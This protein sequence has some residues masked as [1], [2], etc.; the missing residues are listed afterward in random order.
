MNK[1]LQ[2]ILLTFFL[3]AS[4]LLSI[5]CYILLLKTENFSTQQQLLL[6]LLSNDQNSLKPLDSKYDNYHKTAFFLANKSQLS[7]KSSLNSDEIKSFISQIQETKQPLL[8]Y[9]LE[10]IDEVYT[11]LNNDKVDENYFIG[12]FGIMDNSTGNFLLD[13]FFEVVIRNGK[14]S[15]GEVFFFRSRDE[16][17]IEAFRKEKSTLMA[18]HNRLRPNQE[19]ISSAETVIIENKI[20]AKFKIGDKS[21]GTY[22]IASDPSSVFEII[23]KCATLGKG[24]LIQTSVM[25]I[26]KRKPD[27]WTITYD[28]IQQTIDFNGE[29]I[30][31]NKYSILKSDGKRNYIFTSLENKNIPIKFEQ[32]WEN[33]AFT[34]FFFKP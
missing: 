19:V 31:A 33:H 8:D 10:K 6:Q 17:F 24:D 16:S 12:V 23:E 18:S 13:K 30:S 20:M 22:E 14:K 32:S 29:K 15:Y 3:F 26:R 4:C 34:F 5:V 28:G 27:L 7:G 1:L 25:D 11:S 9:Q 2:P 21:Q